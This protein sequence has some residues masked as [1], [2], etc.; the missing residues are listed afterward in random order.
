[1][2]VKHA[3]N[4]D[5]TLGDELGK[6]PAFVLDDGG[7][8]LRWIVCPIEFD[9]LRLKTIEN[10]TASWQVKFRRDDSV[11]LAPTRGCECNYHLHI[12]DRVGTQQI[13]CAPD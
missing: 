7:I 6:R 1:M 2:R 10:E 11:S 3:A 13:P 5:A 12:L 4:H 9:F 8:E